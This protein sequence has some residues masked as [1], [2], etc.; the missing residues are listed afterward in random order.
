MTNSSPEVLR[1]FSGCGIVGKQYK[2]KN[3]DNPEKK[4]K[5]QRRNIIVYNPVDPLN[6]FDR[7]PGIGIVVVSVEILVLNR[8]RRW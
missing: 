7:V 1:R 4:G 3:K 6:S 2:S 8:V 5:H